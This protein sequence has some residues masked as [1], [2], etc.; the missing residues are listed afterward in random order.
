MIMGMFKHYGVNVTVERYKSFEAELK[1]NGIEYV[2]L[3]YLY[4]I[5]F[6]FMYN[7]HKKYAYIVPTSDDG[8]EY[9]ENV[10]ITDEIPEDLSW[11]NIAK[12]STSEPMELPTRAYVIYH[13]AKHEVM[14][15]RPKTFE[16]LFNPKPDKREMSYEVLR[17][18]TTIKELR[19]MDHHDCP[20]LDEE[21]YII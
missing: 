1:N 20:E 13:A 12:D 8:D 4:D 17:Y 7:G 14:Q 21:G 15:N 9:V 2:A 16:N 11:E 18:N 3:P 6:R 5:V 19:E 10:Y